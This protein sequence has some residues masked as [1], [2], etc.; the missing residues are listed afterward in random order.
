MLL[1]KIDLPEVNVID[2]S[3]FVLKTDYDTDKKELILVVF[4]KRQITMLK[5]MK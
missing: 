1:K 2:T 4:L 5:S 3:R